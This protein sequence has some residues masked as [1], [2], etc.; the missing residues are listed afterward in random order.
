MKFD[1]YLQALKILIGFYNPEMPWL[2]MT[3][4]FWLYLGHFK[5]DFDSVKTKV[6]FV[7]DF[8]LRN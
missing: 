8:N 5:S 2:A 3:F 1:N 4:L 7:N 6:G